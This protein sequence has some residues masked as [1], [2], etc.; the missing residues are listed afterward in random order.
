MPQNTGRRPKGCDDVSQANKKQYPISFDR[1]VAPVF[2]AVT[3][4]DAV[5]LSA[6]SD[7][8][9]AVQDLGL[10]PQQLFSN[11]D[12]A[13]ALLNLVERACMKETLL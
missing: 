6:A 12:A 9:D 4:G 3:V 5:A 10:E 1:T 8:H 13:S 11:R 7:H 2:K